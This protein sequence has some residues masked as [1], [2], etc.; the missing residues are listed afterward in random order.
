MGC[1]LTQGSRCEIKFGRGRDVG[2][3][4]SVIA[5]LLASQVYIIFRRDIS[6]SV[7]L[8]PPVGSLSELFHSLK[9]QSP[10]CGVDL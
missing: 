6:D 7:Y 1:N 3:C 8:R 5:E 10:R 9:W 4:Y 2:R